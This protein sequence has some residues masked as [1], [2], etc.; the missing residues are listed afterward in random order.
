M[1]PPKIKPP[2]KWQPG[3]IIGLSSTLIKPVAANEWFIVN[4]TRQ[5]IMRA[6]VSSRSEI[7]GKRHGT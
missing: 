7:K 5:C 6:I 3:F 2:V 4:S 1:I